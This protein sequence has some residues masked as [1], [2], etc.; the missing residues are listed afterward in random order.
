MSK[1]VHAASA[2]VGDET[3]GDERERDEMEGDEIEEVEEYN[4]QYF[5]GRSRQYN[6]V[7]KR[8]RY[9]SEGQE[10][11]DVATGFEIETGAS[12]DAASNVSSIPLSYYGAHRSA[13]QLSPGLELFHPFNAAIELSEGANAEHLLQILKWTG[14]KKGQLWFKFVC[15]RLPNGQHKMYIIPGNPNYNKHSLCVLQGYYDYM[16]THPDRY[17]SLIDKYDAIIAAQRMS[18]MEILTEKHP[19][20]VSFNKELFNEFGCMPVLLSGSGTY[21]GQNTNGKNIVGLNA[22]SGHYRIPTDVFRKRVEEGLLSRF[23]PGYILEVHKVPTEAQLT[24]NNLIDD[25]FFGYTGICLTE[26]ELSIASVRKKSKKVGGTRRKHKRTRRKR[27][28]R[29]TYRR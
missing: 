6:G 21:M 3:E 27:R 17:E 19:L 8:Y 28:H 2:G 23:L 20:I 5:C 9:E 24:K 13:I 4:N 12:D 11:I 7:L 10:V 29:R 18:S 1:R 16:M 15:F 22:K 25:A 14:D 26:E